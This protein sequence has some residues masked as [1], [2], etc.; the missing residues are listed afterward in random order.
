MVI[1]RLGGITPLKNTQNTQN[2]TDKN[3][4]SSAPDSIAISAEAKEMAELYFMKEVAAGT[5]DVRADRIA[6]VK[7]KIQ[8]PDYLSPETI[9]STVDK[10]MEGFGL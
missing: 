7:E 4:F 1:D 5:P 3:A 2:T 8:N 9:S 10:I 6:D